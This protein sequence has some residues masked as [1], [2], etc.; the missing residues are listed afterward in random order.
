MSYQQLCRYA[1]YS[2][3]GV[4]LVRDSGAIHCCMRMLQALRLTRSRP[5]FGAAGTRRRCTATGHLPL[6]ISVA[7]SQPSHSIIASAGTISLLPPSR[8]INLSPHSSLVGVPHSNR[9]TEPR[10]RA[11]GT[12][13]ES[14]PRPRHPHGLPTPCGRA[15]AMIRGRCW[16]WRRKV[17]SSRARLPPN[18]CVSLRSQALCGSLR[19]R[20]APLAVQLAQARRLPAVRQHTR[21][22]LPPWPP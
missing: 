17:R 4:P 5:E 3:R 14:N 11:T 9:P 7:T 1:V 2:R 6:T 19:S 16:P 10:A 8:S 13:P 15:V 20:L 21:N 18:P 22:A 12:R